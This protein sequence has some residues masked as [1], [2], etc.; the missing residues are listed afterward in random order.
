MSTIPTTIVHLKN[1]TRASIRSAVPPDAARMLAHVR[2]I[3]VESE[4]VLSTLD[5]FH[6]TEE[7]E[8]EFIQTN[9][10]SPGKIILLAES[11]G[12]QLIGLLNFSRGARKR[13]AHLGELSMSVNEAWRGQ[14]VG[15]VLL[16][17]LIEWARQ[18][19]GIEKVCLEVFANN[20]RALALYKSLGFQEEGRQLKQ[21]KMESG[22]YI[23]TIPMGLFVK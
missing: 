7:Q 4:F 14:G 17:T 3:F 20:A 11:E 9:Q 22:V 10:D 2:G 15:R 6:M 5:D 21:I 16:A 1:N 13:I 18:E 23:D 8:A 12:G 19:P